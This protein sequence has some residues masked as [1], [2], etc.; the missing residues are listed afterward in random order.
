LVDDIVEDHA[1][2]SE[3]GIQFVGPPAEVTAGVNQGAR[4]IYFAGPDDIPFEL[5]QRPPGA[6]T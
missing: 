1:R 6:G 3:R 5:F 4:A 2:L